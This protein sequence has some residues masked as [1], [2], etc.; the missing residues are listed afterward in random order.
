MG[1][2]QKQKKLKFPMFD[3]EGEGYDYET[4]F[5]LG[6]TRDQVGHLPTRDYETGMILKGRKHP[7]FEKGIQADVDLGYKLIKKGNRYYTV[8]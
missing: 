5:K 3:P 8:K 7:T 4:A 1:N 6:Y 2:I